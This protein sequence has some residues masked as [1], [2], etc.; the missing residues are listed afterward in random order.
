MATLRVAFLLLGT[1]RAAERVVRWADTNEMSQL[2]SFRSHAVSRLMRRTIAT[3]LLGC[4]S[5]LATGCDKELLGLPRVPVSVASPDGVA[6]AFVRNHPN[7]DPPSQSVWLQMGGDTTQLR[8]L[9]PDSDWCNTIVWSADSSTVAY[10]VQDARLLTVDRNSRRVVSEKWLTEWK[11][12]YPPYRIAEDLTLSADGRE[13]VF[14][15]CKRPG[16]YGKRPT[17]GFKFQLPDCIQRRVEI[18]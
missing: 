12:E 4:W 2:D 3:A 9:G 17:E 10:L 5:V 16:V 6:V 8:R 1:G 14:R 11:G 15:D 7:I 13:A 18:R